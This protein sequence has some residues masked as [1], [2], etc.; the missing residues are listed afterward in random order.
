VTIVAGI[1]DPDSG[2][3]DVGPDTL[4]SLSRVAANGAAPPGAERLPRDGCFWREHPVGL[5][6][7]R[8]RQRGFETSFS[9]A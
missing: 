4:Q 6:A 1:R 2:T 9:P 5:F 3:R 8:T 7:D